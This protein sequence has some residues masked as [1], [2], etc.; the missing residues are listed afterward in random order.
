MNEPSVSDSAPPPAELGSWRLWRQLR[1]LRRAEES[2]RRI[3]VSEAEIEKAW[4]DFC[5]QHRTDPASGLPVPRD[6][7]P[8]SPAEIRAAV[9]RDSR[10]AKW[11]QETF[12]PHAREHFDK[13]KPELD[14]AVY[15]MVRVRDLGVARELWFRLKE[16]E[17]TFAELAA[18]YTEGHELHTSGLLGPS[19]FGAMHPA[20]AAH[21][22]GA[23]ER[24]LLKPF[25]VAEWFLVARVEKFLPAEFDRQMQNAMV[26]ELCQQWLDTKL[27][28]A[29]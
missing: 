9:A 27:D 7:A 19:A 11:K 25:Q 21:L 10:I 24:K 8:C 26:E 14:R 6:F 15:S 12:G 16:N 20:L 1:R 4:Q 3:A 29:A 28:E 5:R 13:R 17:A 23:E 2:S 18:R 22:R